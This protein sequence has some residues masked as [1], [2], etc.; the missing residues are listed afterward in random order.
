MAD[1]T[2]ADRGTTAVIELEGLSEPLRNIT[3]FAVSDDA[4][5]VGDTFSAVVPDPRGTLWRAIPD[6]ARYKFYLKNPNI[7]GGTPSLRQSGIIWRKTHDASDGGDSFTLRGSD[8]GSQLESCA[9][10]WYRLEQVS[11]SSF[12]QRLVFDNTAWGFKGVRDSNDPNRQLRQGRAFIEATEFNPATRAPFIVIQIEPGERV[13]DKILEYARRDGVMVNVSA[14]GYLQ[15]FNPIY[16]QRNS[17]Q[18]NY[19]RANTPPAR[20]NNVVTP[21]TLDLDNSK[22]FTEVSVVWQEVYPTFRAPPDTPN[23]GKQIATYRRSGPGT[24]PFPRV[25]TAF[26]NEPMSPE[27]GARR[28]KWMAQRSEFDSFIYRAKLHGHSQNGR[29]FSSDTM[30]SVN[31]SVRN[32]RGNFY[33]PTVMLEG[34]RQ[35]GNFTHVELRKPYLLSNAPLVINKVVV[36]PDGVYEEVQG[37]IS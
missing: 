15:L 14:D 3:Q 16:D 19:H 17:F 20:T 5:Q 11:L 1:P 28:A 23:L 35:G 31:D 34:T 30:A 12:L 27:Q 21:T 2:K 7:D 10:L 32:V 8:L 9:P 4:L 22:I 36:R 26:D 33:C 29:W 13:I 25:M 37:P 18:V 6:Y 24:P